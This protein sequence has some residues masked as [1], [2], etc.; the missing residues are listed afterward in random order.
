[1]YVCSYCRCAARM[2][3]IR[4]DAYNRADV[5][6]YVHTAGV[7]CTCLLYI[8]M[9]TRADGYVEGYI[10]GVPCTCLLYIQMYTRA[11]YFDVAGG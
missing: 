6:V 3:V 1:M 2:S 11:V 9:Y 7:R 10:A 5:C 4:G 8:Q